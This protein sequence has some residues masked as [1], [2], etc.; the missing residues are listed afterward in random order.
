MQ[1]NGVLSPGWISGWRSIGW[2]DKYF[3]SGIM[4]EASAA[5][6]GDLWSICNAS[7]DHSPNLWSC[8]HV[9]MWSCDHVTMWAHHLVFSFIFFLSS[10]FCRVITF[11]LSQTLWWWKKDY[12]AIKK[13]IC[14]KKNTL[15]CWKQIMFLE[16]NHSILIR[17]R[18]YLY[19]TN[20][21]YYEQKTIL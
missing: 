7:G 17:R 8:D 19:K 6:W 14:L 1:C 12:I 5:I 4:R 16:Q 11:T 15:S 18:L 13:T 9:S 10:V 21:L 3:E 20:R 2:D